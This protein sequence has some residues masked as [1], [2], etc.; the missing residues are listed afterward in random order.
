MR[1]LFNLFEFISVFE[2]LE[3]IK[4]KSRDV[5]QRLSQRSA[6]SAVDR[7]RGPSIFQEITD[8][9]EKS[10]LAYTFIPIDM[11]ALSPC[12]VVQNNGKLSVTRDQ[13]SAGHTTALTGATAPIISTC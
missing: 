12:D 1:N 4:Q 10:A 3:I 8:L 6:A 2:V 5:Y 9:I 13:G 7:Y 11:K